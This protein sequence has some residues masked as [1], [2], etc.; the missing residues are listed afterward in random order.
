LFYAFLK[1]NC[2]GEVE[3]AYMRKESGHKTLVE[4]LV[5]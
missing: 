2:N 5:P 4:T 1:D 3:G